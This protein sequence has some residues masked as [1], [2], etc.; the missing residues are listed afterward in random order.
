M[1]WT[2]TVEFSHP[3]VN[4]QSSTA[5]PGLT[6]YLSYGVADLFTWS[7]CVLPACCAS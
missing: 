3:L 5:K 2:P 7:G 4:V 1:P 6:N